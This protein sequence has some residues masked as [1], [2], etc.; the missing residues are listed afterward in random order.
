MELKNNR[1][2]IVRSLLDY[3]SNLIKKLSNF[4]GMIGQNMLGNMFETIVENID[5]TCRMCISG[6]TEPAILTCILTCILH[7]ILPCSPTGNS[8]G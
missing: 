8:T 2:C 6:L 3:M 1:L 5:K 7:C 4:Y